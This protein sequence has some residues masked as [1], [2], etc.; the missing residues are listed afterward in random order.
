MITTSLLYAL[1]EYYTL[2]INQIHTSLISSTPD[3]FI[4]QVK[5]ETIR[6]INLA[7]SDTCKIILEN[8]SCLIDS[9]TNFFPQS[10]P[11]FCPI[12]SI[13]KKNF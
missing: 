12:Q 8:I 9:Q 5:N 4:C 3:Q 2:P 13:L 6:A 11:R 1:V 10:L 7:P